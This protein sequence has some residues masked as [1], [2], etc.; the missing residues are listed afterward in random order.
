MELDIDLND[1][2]T[3]G[4]IIDLPGYLLPPEAWTYGHNMRIVDG[5]PQRLSGRTQ[6]FGTPGVAPHYI[7][8]VSGP[9]QV[10]W[11]YTSLAKAFVYDGTSHTDITRAVGGD[12]TAVN[13]RDWNGTIL[14]G[15]PII[16]NGVDTPQYWANYS[17][18]QKLQALS[19][20]PAGYKAKVIRAFGA[21]LVAFNL[22]KAG[23]VYPHNVLFS[24]TADPGTLPNSWDIAD[25]TKDTGE[26]SLPDVESGT[27]LDAM[28]LKGIMYIGKENSIWRMRNIGGRFLFAFDTYLE[29]AGLLAQ[30]CI[31]NVGILGQQ[32]IW[33]QDD[34]LLHNGSS[35][36]S[37]LTKTWRRG[38]FSQIDSTNFANCFCF[39]NAR[40]QEVWFCFPSTGQVNP[41]M[42][43]IWNYAE[44]TR[45]FTTC[46]IDF[47][48]VSPGVIPSTDTTTWDALTDTWEDDAVAWE[49]NERR[50]LISCATD[51]TKFKSLDQG[52]TN[53]GAAYTATLQRT[54]LSLIGRKRSGEWIVDFKRIKTITRVWLK[55]EGGPVQ[56][57]IGVQQTVAGSITWQATSTFNPATD[58]Y[59][60]TILTGRC[61]AIEISSTASVDWTLMGYRL[62]LNLGGNF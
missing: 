44:Q 15:I 58:L 29:T 51:L 39:D 45:K 22:T 21:Q 32:V 20:W 36:E 10:W 13:T 46:D 27:I 30:R 28:M 9:T 18:G 42:A 61:L 35:Q 53:D 60:D 34:I 54:G 33:T 11:L 31:C 16:N 52:L 3:P 43:L 23:V 26:N 62:E 56:V 2:G 40:Q 19:N 24:H 7:M 17:T 25:A 50:R 6:V 47:R 41:N 5:L 12:Y 8:S 55:I 38:L 48:N 57:R 1:L 49:T 14:G 59:V 4:V 37:I